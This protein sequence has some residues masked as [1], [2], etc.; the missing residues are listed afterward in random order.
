MRKLN[1]SLV[2]VFT[3]RPFDG[4]PL[5]VFTLSQPAPP[6]VMQRIAREMNLAKTAFVC[7][8][9]VRATATLR[10]F[11]PAREVA[12]SGHAV[13]GS[14][15]V[16]ARSAPIGLL[17]FETGAGSIEVLIEREGGFVS[18]CVMTQPMPTWRDVEAEVDRELV[19]AAIGA[20][21]RGPLREASLE[22]PVL[23][24]RV[25][26]VDAVTVDAAAMA[27]LARP[28][29]V[30][31]APRERTVRQR[32]FEPSSDAIEAPVSGLLAGAIGQRLVLDDELE[33]G[34]L[35]TAQGAHLGRPGAVWSYLSREHSP[36]V[37]GACASVGRGNF[38]VP[39]NS[40]G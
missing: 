16:I 24:A 32:L 14:A 21:L 23:L 29:A 36:R 15:Y 1:Y 33:S 34:E 5:A 4:V 27:R 18:R 2:D 12:L 38:E 20:E 25:D 17:R 3:E 11:T 7:P 9:G 19:R 6:A 8:T 10:V 35:T 30:Y 31:E 13:V 39:F 37:G 28:V 40:L 22:T 26:D